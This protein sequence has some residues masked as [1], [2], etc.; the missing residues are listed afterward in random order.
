MLAMLAWPLAAYAPGGGKSYT[1]ETEQGAFTL[2]VF[3][4]ACPD[5]A[6]EFASRVSFGYYDGAIFA[7][8][9]GER[10]LQLGGL[11]LSGA[12]PDCV[13]EP[14]PA[15]GACP[16]GSVC[17]A[18]PRGGGPEADYPFFINLRDNA[19]LAGRYPVFATVTS[20][21]DVV[22]ALRP[23]DAIL[24]ITGQYRRRGVR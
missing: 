7:R 18:M 21:M 14:E 19:D 1:V 23:G 4:D 5:S 12:A 17:W 8:R 24:R 11:R 13:F 20:G 15:V 9:P 6:A 10:L 16:A 2:T 3:S 22:E